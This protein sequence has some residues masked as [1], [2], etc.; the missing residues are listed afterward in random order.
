[1]VA[2]PFARGCS[3]HAPHLVIF[4][5]RERQRK[6]PGISYMLLLCCIIGRTAQVV[7]ELPGQDRCS[8]GQHRNNCKFTKDAK[9]PERSPRKTSGNQFEIVSHCLCGLRMMNDHVYTLLIPK[10]VRDDGIRFTLPYTV[11]KTIKVN[12][13]PGANFPRRFRPNKG[14]TAAKTD[15]HVKIHTCTEKM[16][17]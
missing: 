10:A 15:V 17:A 13:H 16:V 3:E 1:M 8:I 4:R 11:I 14:G 5:L 12:T 7:L 6:V 9:N 2:L